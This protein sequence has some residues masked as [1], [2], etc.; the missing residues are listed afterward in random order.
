MRGTVFVSL[1]L[2][3]ILLA[4]KDDKKEGGEADRQVMKVKP[5]MVHNTLTE[6]EKAEGWVLLFDG[7]SLEGWHLYNNPDAKPIWEVQD[8][9]LVCDPL[10]G[11]GLHGDL[12]TDGVYE[13]FELSFE[14]NLPD[15]GNSGVFINIQEDPAYR[16]TYTTGPEY[17][18]L[19]EKHLDY[20]VESKRSGCF[21]SFA[22]Q[23]KETKTLPE[24]EWNQS[25]IVQQD[26]K[27]E[28]YLNGNLTAQTDFKSAQW[29]AWVATS[30]FKDAPEF[31][32]SS[33][34]HIGLQLWTS[35]V[36]FRNIK[37]REF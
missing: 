30:G 23:E 13:N 37:I 36:R 35:A 14:W 29:K 27:V 6:A 8:G 12:V 9:V 21:Y 15:T 18:L 22:P 28:F 5:E 26:G 24:G 1:L 32:K 19:G 7:K 17:Q 3:L 20:A 31:A 33:E 11:S 2:G 16:A 34:G 4:C 25:R 10:N